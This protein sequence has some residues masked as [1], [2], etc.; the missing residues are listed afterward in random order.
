MR[1]LFQL[2]YRHHV[3]LVFLLLFTACVFLVV[4]YNRH[5]RAV[6]WGSANKMISGLQERGSTL[7]EYIN[8]S[9]VNEQLARANTL[10]RNDKPENFISVNERFA[11]IDDSLH[12]RKYRYTTAKVTNISVHRE[13]NFITLDKGSR[14]GIRPD[15]GVIFN[16]SVVGI[17]KGVS[18]HYSIAIPILNN[19][20][21][22]SVR[23]KNSGE[24]GLVRW[25][26]KDE[27]IASVDDIPKHVPVRDGDTIVT[28]GF[29][30]YFPPDI[31]VGIVKTHEIR[32]GDNFYTIAIELSTPF[33]KLQ[34]V[35][36]VE[37]LMQ[38]EQIQLENEVE[39]SGE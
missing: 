25:D 11:L 13:K 34:Y 28:T 21:K 31:M 32:E 39:Q 22:A 24:F 5:H 36:I 27:T 1:N 18:D 15:M 20:F 14:H 19:T 9:E 35:D 12:Q 10:L 30:T 2:I 33:R 38:D 23:I 37:N 17:I 26:G 16:G 29:S 8:L 4:G 7:R 6:F 3:S